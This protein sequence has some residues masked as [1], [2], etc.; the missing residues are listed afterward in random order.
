MKNKYLK[1]AHI[2][3]RKFRELLKFFAEGLTITKI[4]KFTGLTRANTHDIIQKIRHRIHELSLKEN[5]LFSGDVETDES[6][7]SA[8]RIRGLRGRGAK[9][10]IKVFGLLK[11]ND[12]V[13]TQ[14]VDVISA[15]TLQGI[16]RGK[17]KLNSV[18]HTDAWKI[19]NG[20]VGYQKHYRVIH[21][22]K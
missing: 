3:K 21:N 7:F 20:L 6:Y 1:Q 12:F 13:Y 16:I 15:K 11:R 2:N 9:V 22:N 19:Y 17:V 4:S 14:I 8:R 10:K 18:I 5:P